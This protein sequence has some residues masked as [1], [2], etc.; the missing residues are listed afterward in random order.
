MEP[1]LGRNLTPVTSIS[2]REVW[3]VDFFFNIIRVINTVFD[4]E[5]VDIFPPEKRVVWE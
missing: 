5:V 3:Y 1:V 2:Y 4:L